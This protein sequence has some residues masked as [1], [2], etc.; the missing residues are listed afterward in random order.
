MLMATSFGHK[1]HHQADVSQKLKMAGAYDAKLSFMWDPIY[2]YVT[3][4]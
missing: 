3:I 4:H 2:I 1:G